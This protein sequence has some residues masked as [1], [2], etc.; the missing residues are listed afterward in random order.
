MPSIADDVEFT[1]L[2]KVIC[3]V[4]LDEAP[5]DIISPQHVE[6][7]IRGRK[8]RALRPLYMEQQQESID[9][10]CPV[11][12]VLQSIVTTFAEPTSEDVWTDWLGG[13]HRALP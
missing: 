1:S 11:P 5:S 3:M 6:I 2:L 7:A 10:H 9:L 4:L 8:I 12:A 13:A